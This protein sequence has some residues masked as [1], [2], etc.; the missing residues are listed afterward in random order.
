M[1][2][3]LVN[4]DRRPDRLEAMDR[5]LEAL[6]IAY[7]R[8]SAVDAK[9]VDPAEL[10][11]PFAA[12]GPLGALSPGDM[13]CTSSHIHIWRRIA[14]GPD[15]YAVVLEDDILLSNAASE[16]LRDSA[17]IPKSVDLVKPERY[18]DENQLIV[19][20]KPRLSVK[21]RTLAPLLSRHTGTGGYII[22]RAHAARLANM[23]EKIALPVDH[24]MFNPNNSPAFGWLKPWQLL[25][26]ILDQR[27]AVGG[28]TDIHRTR[29]AT[30]PKGMALVRRQLKRNYYDLRLIPRQVAQVLCGRASVVKIRLE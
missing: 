17:W 2:T 21:G 19:I 13:G 26:A 23:K 7:E 15:D 11:A 27:E 9:T 14:D 22:S 24:L 4:L 28:T 16:F 20:G 8:F 3:Y 6:G 12:R 18:G 25:P 5:Q 29:E 1:R 30:K 10:S